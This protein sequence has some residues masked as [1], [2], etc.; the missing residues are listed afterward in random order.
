MIQAFIGLGCWTEWLDR[1]GPGGTGDYEQRNL[2]SRPICDRPG[3][4]QC[5]RTSNRRVIVIVTM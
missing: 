2:F 5:R 3:A 1:D 4:V